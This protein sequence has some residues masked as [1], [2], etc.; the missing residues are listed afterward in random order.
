[1]R[2]L[3]DENMSGLTVSLL[4]ASGHDVVWVGEER[5]RTPDLNVLE[6]A[7]QERRLLITFDTDFVR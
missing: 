5:P 2:V 4:R 1:M 7:T 6:W 3:A